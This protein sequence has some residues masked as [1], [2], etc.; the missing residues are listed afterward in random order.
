MKW[1]AG[2]NPVWHKSWHWWHS[3][4]VYGCL[5]WTRWLLGW[6]QWAPTHPLGA[7]KPCC[8]KT[9]WWSWQHARPHY[10]FDSVENSHDAI[11]FSRQCSRFT[12]AGR[13]EFLTT[14]FAPSLFIPPPPVAY[15]SLIWR[16]WILLAASDSKLTAATVFRNS[17]WQ[18]TEQ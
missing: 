8:L 5:A 3:L 1:I 16:A 13:D 9:D 6:Y 7:P 18:S 14:N 2:W 17:L 15:R 12:E 4:W 10:G 11:V